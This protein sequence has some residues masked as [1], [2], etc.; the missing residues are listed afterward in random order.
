MDLPQCAEPDRAPP[1][2]MKEAGGVAREDVI[3]GDVNDEAARMPEHRTGRIDHDLA[4][5]VDH[6]RPLGS[7]ALRRRGVADR[8]VTGER[9]EARCGAPASIGAPISTAMSWSA[10]I[11]FSVA[12][13]VEKSSRFSRRSPRIC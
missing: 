4:D 12:G 10:A 8:A 6:Q 3:D 7:S 13:W 1:D 9:A 5:L 2:A 11:R